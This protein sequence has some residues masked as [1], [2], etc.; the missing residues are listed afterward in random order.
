MCKSTLMS[1]LLL[2]DVQNPKITRNRPQELFERYQAIIIEVQPDI[3]KLNNCAHETGQTK[4]CK[5][6][7]DA[8]EFE[9]S[10]LKCWWMSEWDGNKLLEKS[11]ELV[12][13]GVMAQ[14]GEPLGKLGRVWDLEWDD[15]RIV[16]RW[17][18]RKFSQKACSCRSTSTD[19]MVVILVKHAKFLVTFLKFVAGE[20]QRRNVGK[21]C[22]KRAN[23]DCTRKTWRANKFRFREWP[24]L[25]S[26]CRDAFLAV[27]PLPEWRAEVWTA[28]VSR[29]LPAILSLFARCEFHHSFC[30]THLKSSRRNMAILDSMGLACGRAAVQTCRSDVTSMRRKS[31]HSCP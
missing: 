15:T 6:A 10:I 23:K 25:K 12:L 30:Q 21:K 3:N 29:Q 11:V 17:W 14:R 1:C 4:Q 9:R 16:N 24:H 28:A 18:T 7:L 22:R 2:S 20:L 31:S 27:H 13:V 5:H 19:M 26:R 8:V